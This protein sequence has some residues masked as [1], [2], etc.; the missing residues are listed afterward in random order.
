MEEIK[1]FLTLCPHCQHDKRSGRRHPNSCSSYSREPMCHEVAKDLYVGSVESRE[2]SAPD[3]KSWSAVVG[4]LSAANVRWIGS[5]VA[6][7][8]CPYMI[9]D[10]EDGVDGLLKHISKVEPFVRNGLKSGP[11]LIHCHQGASR[12]PTV[13]SAI[14]MLLDNNPHSYEK[15]LTTIKQ[16]MLARPPAVHMWK[17]YI[18]ELFAWSERIA[19]RSKP[20]P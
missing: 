11:V 12:S 4:V 2:G 18:E 6:Q 8:T 14:M 19:R 10:H 1:L 17:G 16:V 3:G 20:H 5:Q 15:T 13:A 7:P 9:V